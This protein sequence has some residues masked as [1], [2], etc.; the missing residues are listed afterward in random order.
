MKNFKLKAYWKDR[1][2]QLGICRVISLNFEQNKAEISNGYVRVYPSL[3]EIELLDYT[4]QKDTNNEEIYEGY[5][6]SDGTYTGT[7]EWDDEEICFM[8][9]VEKH[10]KWK[11]NNLKLTI[12]GNKFET[13]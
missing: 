8:F 3:D 11:L 13:I 10:H 12:V 5:I 1:K 4:G 6:C 9:I 7:I 2:P